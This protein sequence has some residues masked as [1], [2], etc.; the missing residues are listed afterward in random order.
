MARS[1]IFCGLALIMLLRVQPSDAGC[2][3]VEVCTKDPDGTRKCNTQ[4]NACSEV[5]QVSS[6]GKSV[7]PSGEVRY[8][9]ELTD[10][11]DAQYSEI[12]ERI[13]IAVDKI[14]I[15]K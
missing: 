10:L 12:M 9:I 14:P 2:G 1:V 3:N 13:G 15:P 8:S 4:V 7:A 5:P 6:E 11:S